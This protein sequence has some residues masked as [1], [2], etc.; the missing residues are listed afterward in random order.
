[1]DKTKKK[2]VRR[3]I[4]WGVLAVVVAGLAMLPALARQQDAQDGPV[5]SVLEATVKEGSVQATVRGGGTLEAGDGE[6]IELPVDVKITEFL[7]KNGQEVKKGDPVAK[8]DRVSALT[9]VTEIRTSMAAVEKQMETF[10]DEKSASTVTA[11]A[12][13]RVKA[14]YA[15]PGDSVTQVL[16]EHGALALLSLD[17]RMGVTLT[18]SS[19][20]IPGDSI[21]VTLDSG[22][23]VTGR[24]ES[25]LN[26]ELTVTI[27]DN[28][29][30]VGDTVTLEG[31]GSGSLEIHNPWLATAFNG[32]VSQVNIRLEQTVSSG[33]S[34]FT[35]K[36]TDYTAQRELLAE[37]H[38]DYEELLQKLLTWQDTGVIT[39]PCDGLVSGIDTDSTHLLAAEDE[40]LTASLLNADDGDFRLVLLSQVTQTC[41]GDDKCPLN[42]KDSGHQDGCPKACKH[43]TAEGVCTA[44]E[45]FDDCIMACTHAENPKDCPAT[46]AHHTDC[47]KA[48][49]ETTQEHKCPATKYHYDGCIEKCTESALSGECP[50]HIHK[51][52]CI[53]SCI[54][55]DT[56][57]KCTAGHHKADCIES[58]IVSKSADDPCPATKHKDG[59][60][61]QNATYTGQ[62][63]K[64]VSVGSGTLVGYWDSTVYDVVKTASG[65]ARKDGQP[66][67]TNNCV[68]ADTIS[69]S[70]N[71]QA[72]DVLLS[73]TVHKSGENDSPLG[74][75]KISSGGSQMPGFDLSGLMGMMGGFSMGGYGG[76]GSSQTQLYSLDG[77]VLLTVTP[78][79]TMTVTI[80][81]DEKDIAGV[82]TGM[83]AQLTMN[84]LPDET[85]EGQ[86]TRVAQTGSGNGGS[87]KFDVEITLSRES[88]MLPG[89]STTAQLT[90]YEKMDVL[91]LPVAALRDEGGKTLVYTGKDK[92]TGEPANPVEVTTGL[93]DG[94][95]VEILSGIDSGTTVYYLYYDTVTESD[96]VETE[97]SMF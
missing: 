85:F 12:G 71:Y 19:Q 33:G 37:T 29:Y 69:A 44:S 43:A 95:N 8:I 11:P 92:K 67:S 50:A 93:S 70:G 46:G 97:R 81:V 32:T 35:L 52:G 24:V 26:G 53:E 25:N 38:R 90:L 16:V 80:A 72:G 94:E 17:G 10:S 51:K 62:V 30:A 89:M 65:W 73:I 41:T 60:Y 68:Q 40:E 58:C 57:G 31:L 49:I 87:S 22:K 20:L 77:D 78:L 55:A 9:A 3:Y 91:T 82:K 84:A 59:C 96:A 66:F 45:H 5:A 28:G 2:N 6:D 36:D 76:T 86:V 14:I 56:P 23:T 63:F 18:V 83:T 54:S 42:G 79:D 75:V 47:I 88:D 74:L 48:C 27:A 13:G 64:V 21:P 34:L 15:N 61:F 1:M 4:L 7:V 39:A